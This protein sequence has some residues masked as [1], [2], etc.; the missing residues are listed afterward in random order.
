ME[1][2]NVT[3]DEKVTSAENPLTRKRR[4]RVRPVGN[5]DRLIH[6]LRQDNADLKKKLEQALTLVTQIAASKPEGIPHTPFPRKPEP[7][8][9][10]EGI[11]VEL[12]LKNQDL[13]T[14]DRFSSFIRVFPSRA[15]N[16]E[17]I[18]PRYCIYCTQNVCEIYASPIGGAPNEEELSK[19][20]Q[21][22]HQHIAEMR[23]LKGSREL[24]KDPRYKHKVMLG[25][26]YADHFELN[27]RIVGR[28]PDEVAFIK[29]E[30]K[31]SAQETERRLKQWES[32]CHNI[33]KNMSR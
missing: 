22:H 26:L 28:V 4:T 25:R 15:D 20:K 11:M 33:A 1:E 29:G 7:I 8:A 5:P 2:A 13:T 6:E 16:L 30:S 14:G 17:V 24:Y 19:I 23:A 31:T 18:D 9:R 21:L 27:Y 3:T 32:E 12:T 10:P